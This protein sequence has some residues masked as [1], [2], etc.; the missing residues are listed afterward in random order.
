MKFISVTVVVLLEAVC[1]SAA[2][3]QDLSL[4]YT[5][6]A[7]RWLEALPIGNGRLGG[8]IFG[9]T[10]NER[11]QFN[12]QSLW[13]GSETEMGNYQPFGDVFV[14]WRHGGTTDYRRE[15]DLRDAIHRVSYRDGGVTFQREAFSSFPDQVMVLRFTAD[16]PGKYSGVIQ[17]TD[18]H[19]ARIAAA[20]PVGVALG[21]SISSPA[22]RTAIRPRGICIYCWPIPL[23]RICSTTVLPSR[24]MG[25]S[26]A[27]RGLPRCCSNPTPA[28]SSCCLRC[29][30]RGRPAR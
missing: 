20:G 2:P 28:K 7:T 5:Q 4:W 30:K 25:T 8:M 14:A 18:M 10:T 1:V 27:A 21:W 23:S 15:L 22:C 26:V 24:L 29:P 9:G 16:K 13:L 17:L 11:V 12:E 3:A 6:P 19:K